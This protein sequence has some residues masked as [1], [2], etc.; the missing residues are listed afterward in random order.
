[1]KHTHPF[2]TV[3]AV[4]LL[5]ALLLTGCNVTPAA[6][7]DTGT[8]TVTEIAVQTETETEAPVP[9][10]VT[11]VTDRT[12]EEEIAVD[13][14]EEQFFEDVRY[15]YFFPSIKSQ[16]VTVTYSDGTEKN[17]RDALAAGDVT[18]DIL[19]DYGIKYFMRYNTRVAEIVDHTED[20]DFNGDIYGYE[21]CFYMDTEYFYTFPE[22]KG[23]YIDV[24][25]TDGRT[26]NLYQAFALY[27]VVFSV[28]DLDVFGIAYD[29]TPRTFLPLTGTNEAQLVT[30][31]PESYPTEEDVIAAYR[32]AY[33]LAAMFRI[34]TDG[35]MDAILYQ[36]MQYQRIDRFDS[37]E[38]FLAQMYG[39]FSSDLVFGFLWS[40]LTT[41]DDL[42]ADQ[43][44]EYKGDL[45]AV[46]CV[47]G[48]NIHMGDETYTVT[49]M[50]DTA[51]VLCVT[52]EI[53][54]PGSEEAGARGY[55]AFFFSYEY[56]GGNWVF[57][58]FPETR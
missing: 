23:K 3:T 43:F 33:E 37:Y 10:T 16:Y 7:T 1:M 44:I 46:D 32:E 55:E 54:D 48:T 49:Q 5:S 15:A 57:T 25:F 21:D 52:I 42:P 34:A 51:I 53:V 14:M 58:T 27:D 40:T 36:G 12:A 18:P 38:D 22:Q 6:D 17:I 31:K 8:E 9:V 13:Q 50:T 11:G 28:D 41:Q 20:A 24:T 47:R 26:V 35:G 45:Y 56:I 19:D 39:H 29:K 2:R 4:L 30:E